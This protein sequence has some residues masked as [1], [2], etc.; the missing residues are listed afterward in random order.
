MP[1][2]V[3]VTSENVKFNG[4][5][6]N[7]AVLKTSGGIRSLVLWDDLPV[8]DQTILTDF[9]DNNGGALPLAGPTSGFQVVDFSGTVVGGGATGLSNVAAA[10]AGY[11][12]INVGG[13]KAGG[14]ASGLSSAT[15][16]SGSQVVNFTPTI[17]AGTATNLV[18]TAGY[19]AATFTVAKAGGDATGLTNDATTYTT[20][21]TVDGVAK[22]ISVVGSAAQTFT[23][24]LA[25]INTDLGASATAAIVGGN[26]RV[27]SA[28]TGSSSTVLMVT[29]TLF[30]A[31]TNFTAITG[32]VAG[33]GSAA[34]LIASI[35]VDGVVKPI[36]ISP[37]AIT[38]FADV[39]NEINA[40]LGASATAAIVGGDIKITSATTGVSSTVSINPGSLFVALPGYSNVLPPQN[41]GGSSRKYSATVVVDGVIKT[42]N[43]SGT[44]G[45]TFTNVLSEINADLGAAATASIVSG[46]IRI[47]SATTGLA[48]SVKVSDSGFLFDS[49]TG[50]VG[51]S[52]VAGTAPVQ[53][54]ATV[55]V[56][57]VD[58]AISVQ[59]SAAQ[60]FT[61]LVSEINTDLGVD[62][63]A[64]ISGGNIRIASASAGVTSTV[65]I[66][67]GTLFKAL[68]AKGV[69]APVDGIVDLLDA[70]KKTK[71]PNG[72]SLLDQFNV[73]KVGT[74]PAVPPYVKH[75]TKFIYWDGTVWKYLDNDANV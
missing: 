11:A 35:S 58:K 3:W 57:G 69:K 48:S 33:T 49:L 42:V 12:T 64:D 17:T 5:L 1:N 39:I 71:A 44:A 36:S 43:F 60:T 73:I 29:G 65:K 31:L 41:G 18:P 14:D 16:T 7:A 74:K 19:Q 46:N 67:D 38:T 25:E 4:T 22:A 55:V 2:P 30:P 23:T 70:A 75:T 63:T 27:T 66:V 50:Y 32:S 6:D 59:G 72:N 53:Y 47:T 52:D 40:D 56:D 62:A 24:L 9:I 61:A 37:A 26:I 8:A 28:T 13:N 34:L 20:T 21:I 45:T 54:T 10:T 51:I 68:G 15:G